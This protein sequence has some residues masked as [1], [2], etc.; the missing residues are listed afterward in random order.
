MN[1]GMLV[2]AP[3]NKKR[4]VP[5]QAPDPMVEKVAE[6]IQC[7]ERIAA[8]QAAAEMRR[9]DFEERQLQLQAEQQQQV[10]HFQMRSEQQ[11]VEQQQ[12]MMQFMAQMMESQRQF[13][14]TV[15]TALTRPQQHQPQHQPQHQQHQEGQRE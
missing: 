4:R 10:L 12:Q 1:P 5:E 7:R 15:A 2:Q 3:R 13:M 8:T 11:H 6:S 14:A 9:I